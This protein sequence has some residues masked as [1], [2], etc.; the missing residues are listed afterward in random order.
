M[1]FIGVYDILKNSSLLNDGKTLWNDK[2]SDIS[3]S[4]IQKLIQNLTYLPEYI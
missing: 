2:N 3:F 1:Y 4:F